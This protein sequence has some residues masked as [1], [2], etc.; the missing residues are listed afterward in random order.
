V[1]GKVLEIEY[2][3]TAGGHTY[4]CF[5]EESGQQDPLCIFFFEENGQQDSICI[6]LSLSGKEK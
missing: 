3:T 6:F 5:F 4:Q 1:W 2:D